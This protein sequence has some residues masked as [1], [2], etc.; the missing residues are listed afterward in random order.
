MCEVCKAEGADYL[1]RNGPKKALM[2]EHLYKVFRRAVAPVR[3][4]H[5]HSIELFHMGE[6]RFLREHLNFARALARQHISKHEVS[7]SSFGL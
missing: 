6:R 7:E 3:M 5:I 1:F 2:K 4:C